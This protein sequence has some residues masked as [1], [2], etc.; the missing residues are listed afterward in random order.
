[1]FSCIFL[2]VKV[3]IMARLQM[4]G[5][6]TA[7]L[8]RIELWVWS[9]FGF[10]KLVGCQGELLHWSWI[11]L[12]VDL[13]C[14]HHVYSSCRRNHLVKGMIA[15]FPAWN[16]SMI[17]SGIESFHVLC[18]VILLR[19][20]IR[21]VL[22]RRSWL[23][24]LLLALG[25]SLLSQYLFF[26][27][28]LLFRLRRWWAFVFFIFFFIIDLCLQLCRFLITHLLVIILR[29]LYLMVVILPLFLNH[30]LLSLRIIGGLLLAKTGAHILSLRHRRC[31]DWWFW[32]ALF[33]RL[34]F[35]I[36]AQAFRLWLWL[37]FFYFFGIV[38]VG[39]IML[40]DLRSI[41]KFFLGV[42]NLSNRLF[43]NLL[44]LMK[45]FLQRN[46]TF[47]LFFSLCC[48]RLNL[49]FYWR[50]FII[51]EIWAIIRQVKLFWSEYIK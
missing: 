21:V 7:V 24:K 49:K 13:R 25:A 20:A 45:I 2:I 37:H 4:S 40:K 28:L 38:F 15:A 23:P 26:K 42:A 39:L 8:I 48:R 36:T 14:N 27:R 9:H 47:L 3:I 35:V 46:R 32:T 50:R 18:L 30:L 10:I 16:L 29:W 17:V 41:V 6:R 43:F 22:L 44:F 5:I 12:E 34:L 31:N 51:R 11:I 1:M 33:F 19:R